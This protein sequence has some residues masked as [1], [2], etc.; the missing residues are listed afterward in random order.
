MISRR[1]TVITERYTKSNIVKITTSVTTV[2]LIMDEFPAS[3]MSVTSG[4]GPVT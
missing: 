2:I 3:F 4:A 1:I